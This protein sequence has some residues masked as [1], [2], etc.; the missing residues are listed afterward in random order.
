MSS[1]TSSSS[2]TDSTCARSPGCRVRGFVRYCLTCSRAHARSAPEKLWRAKS[3]QAAGPT[4]GAHMSMKTRVLLSVVAVAVL[5]GAGWT[6]A[7]A[8][9]AAYDLLIRNGRVVDGTGN[10]FFVADVGV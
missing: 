2:S 9:P 3:R 10:P 7:Q 4:E 8:P 5:I 1:S 6:F